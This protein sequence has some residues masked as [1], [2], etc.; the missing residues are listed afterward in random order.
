MNRII[1]IGLDVH[2]TNY[3]ICIEEPLIGGEKN[4]YVQTQI[5]PELRLLINVIDTL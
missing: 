1:K 5:K 4:V 3:T 2:T